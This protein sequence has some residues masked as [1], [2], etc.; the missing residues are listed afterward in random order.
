MSIAMYLAFSGCSDVLGCTG[1]AGTA[2]V[3][4]TAQRCGRCARRGT[5]RWSLDRLGHPLGD[6][7]RGQVLPEPVG[8]LQAGAG[9]EVEHVDAGGGRT[10]EVGR[11]LLVATHAS[12]GRVVAD[13]P[14]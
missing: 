3:V 10:L 13:E 2:R 14:K 7:E 4:R 11:H 12:G 6:E 5:F 1:T 8:L 9:A